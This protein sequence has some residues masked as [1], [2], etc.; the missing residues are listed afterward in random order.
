MPCGKKITILLLDFSPSRNILKKQYIIENVE[1]EPGKRWFSSADMGYTGEVLPDGQKLRQELPVVVSR[2]AALRAVRDLQ[3]PLCDSITSCEGVFLILNFFLDMTMIN[4]FSRCTLSLAVFLIFCVASCGYAGV[5][6]PHFSLSNPMSGEKVDSSSFAGKALLVTFFATW[7]PPCRH[8]V[9]ELKQLQEN[10][11]SQGFSVVALSVDQGAG[12]VAA[13]A[14]QE[15]IN[16][17]VLMATYETSEDFGGVFGIPTAF[18]VNK[19]GQ[20]V[21]KYQGYV[22]YGILKRDVEKLIQ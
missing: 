15:N 20:V 2:G 10:F 17:P 11:S 16:Y 1:W 18:L 4:R 13:F 9:P 14:K 5:N 21:K 19:D 6:M 8:E 22:N 7:C 3:S 12:K